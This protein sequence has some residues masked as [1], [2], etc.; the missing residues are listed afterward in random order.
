M[1]NFFKKINKGQ[2]EEQDNLNLDYGDFYTGRSDQADDRRDDRRDDRIEPARRAEQSA[3]DHSAGCYYDVPKSSRGAYEEPDFRSDS[4]R[5]YDGDR[6]AERPVERPAEKPVDR[7][8]EP[9]D[10][11]SYVKPRETWQ[12]ADANG[13]R[14]APAAQTANRFFM[15]FSFFFR[16]KRAACRYFTTITI[17]F[18]RGCT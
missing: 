11:N 7:F 9:V 6:P 17:P 5:Y 16:T 18:M 8:A 10:S 12:E 14:T 3:A 4:T 2:D 13:Y 1:K 15:S